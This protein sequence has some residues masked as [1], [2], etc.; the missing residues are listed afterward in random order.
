MSD[1]EQQL[2]DLFEKYK[3]DLDGGRLEALFKFTEDCEKEL[4]Q[5]PVYGKIH[6]AIMHSYIMS[7]YQVG[8]K[9]AED[10][11]KALRKDEEEHRFH[12]T[13]EETPPDGELVYCVGK[14]HCTQ[15]ELSGIYFYH[16]G[17]WW[18]DE[19]RKSDECWFDGSGINDYVFYKWMKLP[20]DETN[21]D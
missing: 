5:S 14:D 6:T 1:K 18:T 17:Y 7:A 11:Y 15:K 10:Y 13:C 8:R 19:Q 21:E 3:K 9:R 4:K 20:K 16:S 2:I 12:L